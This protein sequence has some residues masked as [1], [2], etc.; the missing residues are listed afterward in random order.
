M[1]RTFLAERRCGA[2]AQRTLDISGGQQQTLVARTTAAP[3]RK[4]DLM[5]A[6]DSTGSMGDEI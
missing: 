1:R 6:L 5:I 3:V 4:F 2:G